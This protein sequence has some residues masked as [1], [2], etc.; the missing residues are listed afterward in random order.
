MTITS[1][2]NRVS[3][4]GN[5]APGVPGTLAF[6]VPFRFLAIS[7]LVVLVRVDA[8]GVDTTKTLDTHYSVSGEGAATGGTVT[9]LIEDGEPQT[10]ETLII[11]GNPAMTQLVDYIAGGTFPAESHEEALDR[12]TLQ[13]TRTREI[14]ERALPL[15]DSSTDGSGQYDANS[16]RISNLGTPTATTDAATKTYTDTLVNNTALGPAPTGLIATGSVTSRLLA[17]RWGE[18]KNVKDFGATGD[19]VTDD[20]V[21][22]QAA[23]DAVT[24]AGGGVFFPDG[25]YGL[26]SQITIESTKPVN[27]FG[28][29]FGAAN[30]SDTS[31]AGYGPHI[32]PM[33]SFAGFAADAR[34][35]IRYQGGTGYGAAGIINGLTFAD[36]SN[37][38]SATNDKRGH[39][40]DAALF[41]EDFS[42]GQVQNCYFRHLNGSC[43]E[44]QNMTMGNIEN[45][46]FLYSGRTGHPAIYLN[47]TV[48]GVPQ[49]LSFENCKVEV[50][51]DEPYLKISNGGSVKVLASGFESHSTPT[52]GAGVLAATGQ[53]FIAFTDGGGNNHISDCH[54]NRTTG[55]AVTIA[56]ATAPN[57]IRNSHWSTTEGMCIETDASS[58]FQGIQGCHFYSGGSDDY[59]V[60]L[61]GTGC[62][63][64]DSQF[65]STTGVKL[66]G[67]GCRA[68]GNVFELARTTD[69]GAAEG[70][71]YVTGARSEVSNNALSW[72][73]TG[74]TADITAIHM[75]TYGP[76]S[77]NTFYNKATGLAS[78][79]CIDIASGG[80]SVTNNYFW[81]GALAEINFNGQE[82]RTYSWGNNVLGYNA[83]SDGG[84]TTMLPV[85]R[86]SAP[87]LAAEVWNNGGKLQIGPGITALANNATPP[88]A[89]G[90]TFTTGGTTTITDFDDGTVGQ[91]I[92]V[93]S[94][95]AVTITDA[96]NI[97]LNG[98]ANFV[99]AAADSLTLVLKAD[100]KWYET[101]RMVNL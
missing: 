42:F 33:N 20:T 70:I 81:P 100:N 97:I 44:A 26:S 86:A 82:Y 41:L 94:E 19:G 99:M 72:Q 53:T 15:T 65:R 3:Y 32:Y 95:H 57:L 51:F 43:I 21:A 83:A 92:T 36:T 98:S 85:L 6:S 93:L 48:Y 80:C 23:V 40:I 49:S 38:A 17:D 101:A 11:Y 75:A 69:T 52:G 35:L 46:Y 66:S 76:V 4:A 10:G 16:N 8:T 39:L 37:G 34:S 87:T 30:G 58:Q 89:G 63:I 18:I 91:T 29:G 55:T 7:D 67:V 24:T 62:S 84:Y 54:F 5:G 14:A 96:T 90:S 73:N 22:I 2:Q 77:G 64:S 56:A 47:G 78:M 79:T 68:T 12:L 1:T 74:G 45:C 61:G 71:I 59:A 27:L 50:C 31:M 88:V 60:K 25:Q 13:S 9:F 28:S